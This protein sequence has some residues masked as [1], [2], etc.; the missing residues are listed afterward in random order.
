[1]PKRMGA[2]MLFDRGDVRNPFL[3]CDRHGSR[4]KE[5]FWE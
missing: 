5:P 2:L 3:L 4:F 1:M